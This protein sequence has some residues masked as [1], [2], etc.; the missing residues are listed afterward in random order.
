[1]APCIK[2]KGKKTTKIQDKDSKKYLL[3]GNIHKSILPL[4]HYEKQQ[5]D[6]VYTTA[7]AWKKKN[8]TKNLN[9]H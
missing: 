2:Y 7:C 8:K 9:I 4:G 6:N 3:K 1:M 5:Y